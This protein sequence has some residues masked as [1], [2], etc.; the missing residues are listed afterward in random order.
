MDLY[1]HQLDYLDDH[2][3]DEFYGLFQ[4]MGCGK[5]RSILEGVKIQFERME[6]DLLVVV[7]LKGVHTNWTRRQV[8]L[9][10]EGTPHCSIAWSNKYRNKSWQADCEAVL[11][12]KDQLRIVAV[13]IEALSQK[14]GAAYK[15]LESLGKSDGHRAVLVLDESSTIKDPKANRSKQIVKLAKLFAHR[16]ILTGTPSTE[17]PFNLWNQFEFLKAGFWGMSYYMFK[18]RYGQFK[19]VRLGARSFEELV[20]YRNLD[21][22]R[23][24]IAPYVSEVRMSEAID[25]PPKIYKTIDVELTDRQRRAYQQ[26]LDLYA[27]QLDNDE[28]VTT[29]TPLTRLTK[30]HQIV[31]GH[32]I[33]EYGQAHP[34]EH[35]RIDVL[36]NVLEEITTKAIIFCRFVQPI[37]EIM[38]LLGDA[39]VEY[40]GRITDEAAREEAVDRFQQDPSVRYIVISLQSSGAYGLDLFAAGAVVYYCN[41]YSL[42]RRMQSEGRAHRPGQLNERVV[43]Y[44][45]V[46]PGTVDESVQTALLNKIDVASKVTS[47]MKDWLRPSQRETESFQ[48]SG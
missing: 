43:Y 29:D 30:L 10:L 33:D 14:Q 35:N 48:E 37:S 28:V 36:K 24:K 3:D 26:M 4:E 39:A 34:L 18:Q 22:L 2:H 40:S 13:N 16:R 1:K 27:A 8:P 45:L 5:T 25:I 19:T 17:S 32:I 46:A 31:T 42:E 47:L 15:F 7:A 38:D 20:S 12:A 11:A 9:W 41:G 6:I 21:E 23:E 44:D